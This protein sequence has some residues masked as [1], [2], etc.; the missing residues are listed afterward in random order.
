M[1]KM[2]KINWIEPNS[3]IIF[4]FTCKSLKNTWMKKLIVIEDESALREEIVDILKFEGYKILSADNGATGLQLIRQEKPDLVLCDI[5]MP[6]MDGFEVLEKLKSESP[7][8]LPPFIFITALTERHNIRKGME[9][10]ADD[11]LTKPF[12][13][14]EL[15]NT[16]KS[17]LDKFSKLENRIAIATRQI[18]RK[19]N[20]EV[21]RLKK[22]LDENKSVIDQVVKEKDELHGKLRER[23]SELMEEVLRL[24]ETQNI[25]KS[26]DDEIN[27][28]LTQTV[29]NQT[30]Q[31]K[32]KSLK[33][34]L[35]QNSFKEDNW[36]IF[37]LKIN[38]TYPGFTTRLNQQFSSL[39]QYDLVFSSAT[40]MGM[41]TNEIADMLSI[42]AD[43][44]RKSRYRLKKKMG[45]GSDENFHSFI[46]S[47]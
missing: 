1:V 9:F 39:T 35:R 2:F 10:G 7:E 30:V 47:V 25:L 22:D 5:M 42:S 16:I 45:I 18:E 41:N 13:R 24:V 28:E 38:N 34:K 12:T 23:D 32:L 6:E 31:E 21:V 43:S 33:S 26:L 36:A 14:N 4:T 19:L 40:R 11:Y 3:M 46:H 17:R 29:S 15:L 37:L 8:S 20:D 44:V 27:R